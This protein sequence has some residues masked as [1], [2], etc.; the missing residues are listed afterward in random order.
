[1]KIFFLQSV[2]F[3]QF[4]YYNE[5]FFSFVYYFVE[6]LTYPRFC[7]NWVKECERYTCK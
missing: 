4:D 1:M 2:R 6:G 3:P 5:N 7:V